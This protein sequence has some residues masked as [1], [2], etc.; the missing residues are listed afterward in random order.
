MQTS[1]GILSAQS[2]QRFRYSLENI[3]SILAMSKISIFLLVSVAE[4]AGL[5]ITLSET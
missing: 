4:Q 2:D 5:N 1:L 3:I